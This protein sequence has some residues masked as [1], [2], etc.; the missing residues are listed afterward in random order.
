[1]YTPLLHN[2]GENTGGRSAIMSSMCTPLLLTRSHAWG[3][4]LGSNSQPGGGASGASVGVVRLER[5]AGRGRIQLLR[6]RGSSRGIMGRWPFM[7]PSEVPD[8][9]VEQVRIGHDVIAS[10]DSLCVIFDITSLCSRPWLYYRGS[11]ARQSSGSCR[12]Q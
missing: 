12:E 9:L 3:S 1:M 6:R 11:P 5:L 2:S 4:L 7:P 10:I 8:E